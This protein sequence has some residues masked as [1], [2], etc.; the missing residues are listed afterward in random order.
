MAGKCSSVPSE[1]DPVERFLSKRPHPAAFFT[2]VGEILRYQS[3]RRG[4][5]YASPKLLP[6]VLVT[7]NQPDHVL[8]LKELIPAPQARCHC[9]L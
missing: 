1:T 4:N 6:P 7:I 9:S 2:R 8:G 5:A 3:G